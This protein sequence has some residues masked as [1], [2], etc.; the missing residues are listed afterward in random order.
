M[1]LNRWFSLPNNTYKSFQVKHV[2]NELLENNG[3][4][5]DQETLNSKYVLNKDVQQVF[6]AIPEKSEC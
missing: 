6:T 1:D 2:Y 4:K 3:W 5:I